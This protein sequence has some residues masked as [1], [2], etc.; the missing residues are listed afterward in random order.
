MPDPTILCNGATPPSLPT[1]S[2]NGI[3]GTWNP[4][5]I[6]N[7]TSGGYTFTPTTGLCAESIYQ[8]VIVT[9]VAN[10]A[11]NNDSFSVNYPLTT[12]ITGSVLT[13]DTYLGSN[14]NSVP[15]NLTY[16][17]TPVGTPPTIPNG[18]I[19][20]NT[21]GTYTIQPNTTPGTYTYYYKLT[22][23]CGTTATAT[24]QI[25][26]NNHVF[27]SNKIGIDFC[28]NSSSNVYDSNSSSGNTSLFNFVTV[29]GQPANSNN[30]TLIYPT[31]PSSIVIHADGTVTVTSSLPF[32]YTFNYRVRST[33]TGF[34]SSDIACRITIKSPLG[35]STDNVT[36]NT[37]GT[38]QIAG[39]F[40]VLTNDVRNLCNTTN[41]TIT[42][43]ALLS[44]SVTLTGSV[45][46]PAYF[47][48]NNGTGIVTVDANVGLNPGT[49]PVGS[50]VLNYTVCDNANLS[51]CS[52]QS[53]TIYV[54]N[55]FRMVS[56]ISRKEIISKTHQV[57][58]T[59][60]Q[61]INFTDANLKAKLLDA[62]TCLILLTEI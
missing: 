31:L 20:L 9:S 16:T 18:G 32:S 44:G 57:V 60:F 28:F 30:A 52:T 21:N 34:E 51:I 45:T 39:T 5:S 42:T 6:N 10:F 37:S 59:T 46:S 24:V 25:V 35:L 50:Y 7:T 33:A 58:N 14:L 40:N 29:E 54:T 13:N 3:T 2:S 26:I 22:T 15:P 41:N 36:Y 1:T 12:V 55:T 48:I 61:V 8:S 49:I 4:T 19:T 62:T 17:V 11:A 38:P 43:T 27:S 23:S 53:L 47:K 56:Q